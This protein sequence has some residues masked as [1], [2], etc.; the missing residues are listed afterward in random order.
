MS[1]RLKAWLRKPP[2]PVA[3]LC[4]DKRLEVPKTGRPWIELANSI[5]ALAPSK[6]QALGANGEILRAKVMDSSD[7]E[8]AEESATVQEG[9]SDIQRF[10]TLLA[11]AYDK[12]GKNFAPLLDSA[13]SFIARQQEALTRL[14]REIERLRATNHKLQAELIVA[15]SAVG[16]DGE[17]EP[18]LLGALMQG[19]MAGATGQ[20]PPNPAAMVRRPPMQRPPQPRRDRTQPTK[21]QLAQPNGRKARE[22]TPP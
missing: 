11:D 15:T 16:E 22:G 4:D 20:N 5:A 6:L 2:Q 8:S 10:A 19:A 7:V 13:M 21:A 9:S 18:S 3:V 12:S 14:E 1:A 17:P